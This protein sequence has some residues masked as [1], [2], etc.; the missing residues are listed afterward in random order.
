MLEQVADAIERQD[1]QTADQLLK[2]LIQQEPENP[3]VQFYLA[4]FYEAKGKLEAAEKAYRQLLCNATHPKIVSQARQ[5]IE[6]LAEIG[7]KQRDQ[8]LALFSAQPGSHELSVLVLEPIPPELKKTAAQKFAQIVGLDAYSAH[9]QLPSRSWRLYRTGPLG[10][11]R[12]LTSSLRKAEIPCFC[13]P[14][15]EISEINVYQVNYFQSIAPQATV[16]YQ[17]E[18]E[19]QATLNFEWSEVSQ[20]VEGL[21]P[22]F[23]DALDLDVRGEL[24]RKTKTADYAQ[25]CDLHL[26]GRK[27]IL[28]LCD[29]NYDFHQGITFSA[30]PESAQAMGQTTARGNWNN[31]IKS[32]NQQLPEI[33]IWSDFK[34]F[35]ETAIDFQEMLKHIEPHIHHLFRREK[36]PWDAAFQLYSGLVFLGK[37]SDC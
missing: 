4:R 18:Q 12:F 5:G 19:N 29:Q 1:Y 33:P 6:R 37:D 23:D 26:P 11:L 31:L 15:R 32:L 9:L 14:I 30:N 13:A 36:T 8:D 24:Q 16:V 3:W 10:E 7:Q 17:R 2:H 34:A 28:R 27:S 35:A 21:L 20:R 25:C 22:L